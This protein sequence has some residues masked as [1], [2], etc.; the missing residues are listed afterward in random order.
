MMS[1]MEEHLDLCMWT[2][3]IMLCCVSLRHQVSPNLFVFFLFFTIFFFFLY[4]CLFTYISYT[5]TNY[6]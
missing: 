6:R 1:D 2:L 5:I 3:T 4:V